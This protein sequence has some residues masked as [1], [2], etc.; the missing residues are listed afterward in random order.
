MICLQS[1]TVDQ[2]IRKYVHRRLSNDKDLQKWQKDSAVVCA[3]ELTLM[4][5]A[6]GM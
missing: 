3:I 4:E 1:K 2:D 6:N 5:G